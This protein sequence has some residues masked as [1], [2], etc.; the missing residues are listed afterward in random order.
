MAVA[1]AVGAVMT[2]VA[3][4]AP[5]APVAPASAAGA[6]QV[7]FSP[8]AGFRGPNGEFD[9]PPVITCSIVATEPMI[10]PPTNEIDASDFVYC[11]SNVNE[12][13]TTV[14][15]TSFGTVVASAYRQVY[16]Y[17]RVGLIA[18]ALCLSGTY[19][20]N[21]DA[22]IYAPPGYDPQVAVIYAQSNLVTIAFDDCHGGGGGGGG[23]GDPHCPVACIVNS[24]ADVVRR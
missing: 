24:G 22:F 9:D 13:A 11:T 15:L 21:A 10:Y 5:A 17:D 1:V 19:G 6:N 7:T 20:T 16:D 23:G 12:I 3:A 8:A 4:P 18:S 2:M 14:E